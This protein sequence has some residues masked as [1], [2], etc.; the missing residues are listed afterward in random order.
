MSYYKLE[1]KI[2]IPEYEN[3]HWLGPNYIETNNG[4]FSYC[5]KDKLT[6][7][8]I[9]DLLCLDFLKRLSRDS[10]YLCICDYS[11]EL[12]CEYC[13]DHKDRT[14]DRIFD[15]TKKED[16]KFLIDIYDSN[17]AGCEVEIRFNDVDNGRLSKE[18]RSYRGNK[19]VPMFEWTVFTEIHENDN[20]I[21]NSEKL[22]KYI[23]SYDTFLNIINPTELALF[24]TIKD[25]YNNKDWYITEIPNFSIERIKH[26]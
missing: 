22:E 25:I 5:S 11:K 21:F 14:F 15:V 26:S 9:K 16:Y 4:I 7:I 1:V 17:Q 23:M 2:N 24:D 8:N 10:F 18:Y 19:P 12:M 3:G 20:V 13:K 6:C